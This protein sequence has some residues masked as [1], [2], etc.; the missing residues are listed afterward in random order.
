MS[1]N[2]LKIGIILGSTR[3]TRVGEQVAKWVTEIAKKRTDA[4]YE[5]IDV[6]DYNLPLL[7]EPVSPGY[8]KEYTKEHTKKWSE[9]IKSFDGYVFVTAEYNHSVPGAL[10]NAIDFLYKEWNNKAVGFVAYGSIGGAR[11]IEHLRGISAELQMADVRNTAMLTLHDDF[12]NYSVFKPR[13]F[14]VESVNDVLDQ[15]I[16]WSKAMKTLRK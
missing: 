6:K 7:D 14:K 15:V 5:L 8:A 1:D 11:V 13:E 4:E 3:P 10:K 2:K 16:D 9:K 12:E